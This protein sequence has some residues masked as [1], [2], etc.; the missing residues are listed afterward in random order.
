VA[1]ARGKHGRSAAGR[2]QK[3]GPSA[4]PARTFTA[5]NAKPTTAGRFPAERRVCAPSCCCCCIGIYGHS[6]SRDGRRGCVGGLGRQLPATP[7]KVSQRNHRGVSP[8]PCRATDAARAQSENVAVRGNGGASGGGG[9]RRGRHFG[10]SDRKV[11][12]RPPTGRG[13]P[14]RATQSAATQRRHTVN[15][16]ASR[17][18]RRIQTPPDSGISHR[19]PHTARPIVFP[20]FRS[21]HRSISTTKQP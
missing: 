19:D 20:S 10:R 14:G 13:R 21:P 11:R 8:A 2:A 5:S 9:R 6:C 16:T 18:K 1:A 15:Q 4:Q 3:E 12:R 7:T 17:S